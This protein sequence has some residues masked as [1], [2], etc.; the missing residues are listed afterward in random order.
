M[1]AIKP[2]AAIRPKEEKAERIAAL[3]YL[4]LIHI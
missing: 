2:F 1:A 4:S 3:P